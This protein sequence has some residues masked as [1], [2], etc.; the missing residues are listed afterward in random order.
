MHLTDCHGVAISGN[1]IYSCTHRNL[2][3]E[4]SH[5]INITGNVFRRHNPAYGTGVRLED[6]HDIALSGCTIH[7]EHPDGQPSGA[8]LLE[9]V[10]CRRI[11]VSGCQL[12]DGVPHGLH[13]IDCSDV[14]VTGC[15]I[16]D[17]RPQRQASHAVRFSGVGG[18]NLVATSSLDPRAPEP[19]SSD[20][21]SGV[22]VEGNVHTL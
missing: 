15:T 19:V 12:L 7:D 17:T 22:R 6:C 2:L 5:H 4:N 14:T 18:G 10:S 13:A 16:H 21:E 11:N 3:V 20:E 9:L 1:C 8:S